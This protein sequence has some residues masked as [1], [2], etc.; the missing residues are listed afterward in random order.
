MVFFGQLI[1]APLE[2]EPE[3]EVMWRFQHFCGPRKEKKSAVFDAP[4]VK[5]TVADNCDYQVD[6]TLKV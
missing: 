6:I 2:S 3:L 1:V 4:E 5:K